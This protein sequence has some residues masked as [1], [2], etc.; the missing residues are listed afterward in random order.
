L[1]RGCVSLMPEPSI[2]SSGIP[3][4]TPGGVPFIGDDCCCSAD[5]DCCDALSLSTATLTLQGIVS[6]PNTGF[7]GIPNCIPYCDSLNGTYIM[8]LA[9]KTAPCRWFREFIEPSNCTQVIGFETVYGCDSFDAQ[10]NCFPLWSTYQLSA[11]LTINEAANTYT[12]TGSLRINRV[13]S[14]Q[15]YT[16]FSIA[17][18]AIQYGGACPIAPAFFGPMSMGC[19]PGNRCT[20][21]FCNVDAAFGS[22]TFA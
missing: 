10:G 15:I 2:A 1:G 14:P 19:A 12:A 4:L 8:A 6:D 22:I 16:Q 20:V 11:L 17:S 18:P 13:A 21:G 7:L 5:E 3:V 9:D